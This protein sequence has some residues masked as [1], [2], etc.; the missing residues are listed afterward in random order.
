MNE[1]SNLPQSDPSNPK[2]VNS[3]KAKNIALMTIG[4]VFVGTMLFF[5]YSNTD[6]VDVVNQETEI[7]KDG[8]T[9]ESNPVTNHPNSNS[10]N[11]TAKN[12]N[13]TLTQ[14]FLQKSKQ[15][16]YSSYYQGLIG[17]K[18]IKDTVQYSH[19]IFNNK[20]V[21]SPLG[22]ALPHTSALLEGFPFTTFGDSTLNIKNP[23]STPLIAKLIF[24]D[25]SDQSNYAVRHF[26]IMPNSTFVLTGLL[27]GT[28]QVAGLSSEQPDFSFVT[29]LFNIYDRVENGNNVELLGKQINPVEIF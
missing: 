6:K 8:M 11:S 28:Y 13:A 18:Q 15:S 24:H 14:D 4:A 20:I 7:T 16:N 19:E 25:E 10:S 5:T 26:Y 9:I 21:V 3:N 27:E 12:S 22:V 1:L 29:Q 17:S 23:L 2:T